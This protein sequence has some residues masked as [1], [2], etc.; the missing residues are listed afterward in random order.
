MFKK[1]GYSV[2]LW[3]FVA[4]SYL[5]ITVIMPAVNSIVSTANATLVATSNM[6]NYPG[7]QPGI[8]TSPLW[9]Y[10]IPALVGVVIQVIILKRS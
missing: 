5:V 9:L 4:I 1:L 2:I 7:L 3:V 6:S 10:F 8:E